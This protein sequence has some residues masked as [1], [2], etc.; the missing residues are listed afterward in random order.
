MEKK[1]IQT[2]H[3]SVRES[4]A[5]A[6]KSRADQE[7]MITLYKDIVKREPGFI[8]AREKLRD[9]ER[10]KA[11]SDGFAGKMIAQ[12]SSALRLP[13]IKSLTRKDPV[14]AMALCEDLLAKTLQ[15]PPVLQAL[16]EAADAADALFISIEALSILRSF[17][18]K[19]EKNLRA[20]V[21]YMQ[22]NNQA[23]D[24]VKIFQEIA[25]KRPNDTN[26][27]AELRA[28][29]ALGSIEQGN[30]E[31]NGASTQQK[32][33]DAA[34]AVAQQLIDGTIHDADQARI[35]AEKYLKDLES[36]ESMDIRRKL[37]DAYMIMEDYDA[38]IAQYEKVAAAMGA[39]DP[40]IDK[41]IENAMIAKFEGA[42]KTL[43]EH[44][45]NYENA[46]QQIADLEK[47]RDEYQLERARFRV[48]TYPNDAI[49]NY[50]LAIMLFN[51]GLIGDSIAYFQIA[52]RS[53]LRR[54][55]STVYLGRCFAANRQYDMALEQFEA[56]LNEMDRMD[57]TKIETIYFMAKMLEEAGQQEKA[58]EKYKEIYQ[59]QANYR[60]VGRRIQDYYDRQN[61]ARA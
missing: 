1:T 27:Q 4:Y 29:M 26:L 19:N 32:T 60:D 10:R 48:K 58:I 57:D 31:D 52:R 61:N 21:E 36:N 42:I 17:Q 54:L 9:L 45:E 40:A 59:T 56:A 53:P 18:P 47:Q 37:A 49:L 22:R 24:A 39:M 20:L 23:K 55:A 38:A 13:K 2:V 33:V 25:A 6:A 15:N 8:Q 7:T 5:R 51:C 3:A 16:A 14:A 41:C 43:K 50:E 35:I 44:P 11:M 34:E 12:L 46:A 30:W 28:A